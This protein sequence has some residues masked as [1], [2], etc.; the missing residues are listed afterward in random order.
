[1]EQLAA[2]VPL[3]DGGGDVEALVALEPDQFRAEAAGEGLGDLRLADAGLTLQEDRLA[4]AERQV[5]RGGQVALGDVVLGAQCRDHRVDIG[6]A[7]VRAGSGAL[8]V[9]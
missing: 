4:H 6:E 5:D 9:G 1:V 3:V 2:I 8:K 7:T